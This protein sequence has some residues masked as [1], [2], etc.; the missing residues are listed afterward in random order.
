MLCRHYLECAMADHHKKK[1]L[2]LSSVI[3]KAV[4]AVEDIENGCMI[5][6][7]YFALSQQQGQQL[8]NRDF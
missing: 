5:Y 8:V 1:M 7:M 2:K 4:L 6:G 3:I